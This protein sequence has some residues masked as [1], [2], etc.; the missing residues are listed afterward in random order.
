[1]KRY[2]PRIGGYEG[3][4]YFGMRES[5]YGNWYKTEDIK[6]RLDL[7]REMYDVLK[8]TWRTQVV[9]S[10]VKR[11]INRYEEMEG[12]KVLLSEG[13]GDQQEHEGGE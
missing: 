10:G 3:K 12:S 1:M 2:E 5:E 13:Y 6:P 9:S 4:E 11:V 7:M 8:N